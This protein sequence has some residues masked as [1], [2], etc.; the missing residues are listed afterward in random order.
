M[1]KPV[2]LMFYERTIVSVSFFRMLFYF[3]ACSYFYYLKFI[4]GGVAIS[5]KSKKIMSVIE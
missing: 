3:E 4:A 5:Q 1:P 2:Y